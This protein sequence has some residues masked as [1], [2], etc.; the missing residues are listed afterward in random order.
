MSKQEQYLYGQGKVK[1]AMIGTDGKLGAWRWV[2]D[3]SSLKISMSEETISHRESY[4]GIKAKVREFGY[5]PEA[6]VDAVLHSVITDNL[7]LFTSGVATETP[8]GTVTAEALPEL[9][10][11]DEVVLDNPGITDVVITDSA[12]SPVTV[13]PASYT[14]DQAYGTIVFNSIDSA[15]QQPFNVAYKYVANKQVSF[16]STS[17]R[18]DVALRYEGINLAENGAPIIAEF[19]KCA[20]SLLTDLS[21]ITDGNEVAGMPVNF[22]VLLDGSKPANGAL[23]QFGRLIQVE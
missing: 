20:P 12:A 11:G 13:D 2:G 10:A 15:L 21:L 8:A 23:G 18:P 17:K 22:G 7:A 5:S 3:V 4:S 16:L 14:V 6:K 19:Y 1:I 9:Q